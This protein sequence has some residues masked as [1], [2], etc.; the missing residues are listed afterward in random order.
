MTGPRDRH[1]PLGRSR[2]R[3]E[4]LRRDVRLLGDLLGRVLVEQG[5]EGLLEVEERLRLLNRELRADPGGPEAAAREREVERIVG[6]LDREGLV[7]VIRAF[8]IYFQLVNAAEQ[9]HRVRRRR[10]RDAERAAEGRAQPESLAAALAAL[11]ARGVPAERVQAA[12]DR[13]RIE[14]VATAH[15][16]EIARHNVLEKHLMVD[17]CLDELESPRSPREHREAVERLLEAITVLWQTDAL[18]TSRPE[19]IDEVRRVVFFLEHMLVDAAGAVHEE[20]GRVLDEHYPGV[21]AHEDILT[22]GSWAGGDQDG[23]PNCTPDLIPRALGRHR[24]AALRSLRERVRA[25]AA[26]LSLSERMVGVSDALRASLAADEARMPRA[27]PVVAARN[28]GEPYRRKLSFVWERLDPGGEAPYASPDEMIADLDVIRASLEEHRGERIARRGLARLHRRVRSFGFHLARLDVRQHSS[29]LR[30]AAAAVA[31]GGAP[32]GRAAEVVET[33]RR[34]RE[35]IDEHGPEAAGTV[36]VSFT[37]EAGDLLA[38]LALARHAGLVRDDGD[39]ALRSDVDLVPLFET[40]DDLR[41][42]PEMMRTLLGT[43]AYRRNVEARGDRQTVMVGY[44]DS[45]KDGGY[46]ASNWELFLAQQRIADA[47]RLDGVHLTL[48]H[49]RGGSAGR[50]GAST[51]GAVKGGPLGTLDG[52]IRITEQGENLSSKYGLPP[53]AERNLDSVVAAVLERTLEE[54]EARGFSER[55][56]V[57][58]EAAAELA[59]AS[60]AAY[61]GL[62]YEDPGFIPYFT[63]ASPIE[64]LGLLNIGSRPARR[65]GDGALRVEDLRAIPWVF[66]WTQNRH[67]LPSWY[68]VGTAL[69]AFTG[70]YRGAAGVLREMYAGWP[71]WRVVVDTCHMAVGKADMRVAGLYAGLVGDDALRERMLGTVTDEYRRTTEGL[72]AV[73]GRERLLDDVPWLQSSIRLR[74]PYVD[75]LHAIQIRLLRELR[76]E[77]DPARRAELEHPLLLTVSGIAAGLRNTG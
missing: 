2:E 43:P 35:A 5:G 41:R 33:F 71:W 52:R 32:E 77:R 10:Q 70:R 57:W 39:G 23:N 62:V 11:R 17:A 25:L 21:A 28:P 29:I 8:S 72:L 12:L 49:G 65:A 69:R 42:A 48:F 64:E 31:G 26:E 7:G 46:L 37:H 66:A 40:I 54:D 55:K 27:A 56:P 51:Y 59:A 24:T 44:S 34:L 38:P 75:P 14:L 30:E 50:G 22:F 9:H 61:R 58:D 13:M 67:L 4:P 53:I 3:D 76:A 63:Q 36:I 15:P 16:T 19:A 74:N 60:M 73:V 45:N 18:R 20:L 6:G 68:G 1:T 47:C